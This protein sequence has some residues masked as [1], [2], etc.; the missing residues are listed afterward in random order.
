MQ[1]VLHIKP[2]SDG[3]A[4]TYR[5]WHGSYHLMDLI[6][7]GQQGAELELTSDSKERNIDNALFE[8]VKDA[9]AEHVSTFN[10]F[11]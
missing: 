1:E 9:I 3:T 2:V 4:T 5:A 11:R 10:P 6:R 8:A 7:S